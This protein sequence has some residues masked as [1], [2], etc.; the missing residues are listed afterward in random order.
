MTRK[1]M[2]E[3]FPTSSEADAF[4]AEHNGTVHN[5]AFVGGYC[6]LYSVLDADDLKKLEEKLDER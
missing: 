5:V 6:V 4:A 3:W 1:T 2:K